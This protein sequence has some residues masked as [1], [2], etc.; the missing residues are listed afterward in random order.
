[1][2]VARIS[3]V[4]VAACGVVIAFVLPDVVTGLT[5]VWKIMAFLGIPFWMAVFWKRGN[6]YGLW[7][8]LLVTT[9]VAL[10]TQA[11]GWGLAEQILCY[12]PAGVLSFIAASLLTRPEPEEQLRAFYTLLHTPVGEEQRLI[13]AG[14]P[15]I[16]TGQS[17]A[18]Q[19]K[20]P[21]TSLEEQGHSLLLVDLFSLR[22]TFSFR[23]YRVDILGFVAATVLILV[24]IGSGLFL[25]RLGS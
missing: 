13:D 9:S 7:A 3:A 21:E 11:L 25:S 20:T 8:S 4:A 15:I 16:L 1:M 5:I 17:M 18:S 19:N 10:V 23:K 2:K 12:L 6:R 14:I 24:I 22:R